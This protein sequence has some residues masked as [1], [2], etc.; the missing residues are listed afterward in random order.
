M[1]NDRASKIMEN[2]LGEIREGQ[3]RTILQDCYN[4]IDEEEDIDKEYEYNPTLDDEFKEQVA[5]LIKYKEYDLA[6]LKEMHNKFRL[7][8]AKLEGDVRDLQHKRH[9]KLD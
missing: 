2:I 5:S 7:R 3:V 8:L 1:D 6:R 4:E 9:Y